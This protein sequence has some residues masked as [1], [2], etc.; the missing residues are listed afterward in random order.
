MRRGRRPLRP[1][2]PG[3]V[4]FASTGAGPVYL[5]CTPGSPP[6][7]PGGGMTGVVFGVG[8][9]AGAWMPGSTPD[10]GCT[11][12]RATPD[13]CWTTSLPVGPPLRGGRGAGSMRSGGAPWPGWAGPGCA[14][15]VPVSP[16]ARSQTATSAAALGPDRV[17]S[18]LIGRRPTASDPAI[19]QAVVAVDLAPV[20]RVGRPGR[21]VTAVGRATLQL[22]AA[23]IDHVAAEP[24]VVGEHAP[25]Q[26]VIALADAEEAAEAHHRVG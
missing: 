11:T 14:S 19:R 21:L 17:P 15:A 8:S 23:D 26:R 10:G 24:G 3:P 12:P 25:G 20:V 16:P 22:L 4:L 2:W 13:P 1:G 7:V 9:G 5:G 6:G 18:L